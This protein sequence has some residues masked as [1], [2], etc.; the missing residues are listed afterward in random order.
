MCRQLMFFH[1]LTKASE[2]KGGGGLFKAKLY[3]TINQRPFFFCLSTCQDCMVNLPPPLFNLPPTP[4]FSLIFTS[5]RIPNELG[6]VKQDKI[7][8]IILP[9]L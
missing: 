8:N 1:N 9:T 7:K 5:V 3:I 6:E 4:L 2:P